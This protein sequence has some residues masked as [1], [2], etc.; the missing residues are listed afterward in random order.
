MTADDLAAMFEPLAAKIGRP[1]H[2]KFETDSYGVPRWWIDHCPDDRVCSMGWVDI[3]DAI[4]ESLWCDLATEWLQ[5]ADN[6]LYTVTLLALTEFGR[7]TGEW[8][9]I[10]ESVDGGS[11][12]PM[13][14]F[15]GGSRAEA[16]AKACG[17]VG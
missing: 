14:D 1:A 4:A 12:Y 2:L 8:R 9:C 16:L 3:P 7:P 6:C 17:A 5:L 10:L 13:R 15:D 11:A